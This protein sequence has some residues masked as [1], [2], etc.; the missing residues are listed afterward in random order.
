MLCCIFVEDLIFDHFGK[1]IALCFIFTFAILAENLFCD[2][3][4]ILD[5]DRNEWNV[6][7]NDFVSRYRG[8]YELQP[9]AFISAGFVLS[10]PKLK[11]SVQPDP[12]RPSSLDVSY[13]TKATYTAGEIMPGKAQKIKNIIC[14]WM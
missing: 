13:N 2:T 1:I 14:M 3:L 12:T 11:I 9:K 10:G 6:S 4:Q 8:V 5:N 7:G